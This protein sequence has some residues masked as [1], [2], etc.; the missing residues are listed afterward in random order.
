VDEPKE[1]REEFMARRRAKGD[2]DAVRTWIRNAQKRIMNA[3]NNIFDGSISESE[4][5][6]KAYQQAFRRWPPTGE[7]LSEEKEK[8]KEDVVHI[9][10]TTGSIDVAGDVAWAYNNLNNQ[11]VRAD[12]APSGGAWNM[13]IYG[14]ESRHKFLEMAARYDAQKKKEEEKKAESFEADAAGMVKALQK[15]RK[16][17][18]AVHYDAVLDAVRQAPDEVQ[19]ALREADWIVTRPVEKHGDTSVRSLREEA[20]FGPLPEKPAENTH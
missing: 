7:D 2:W 13:L 20:G 6:E 10:A 15:L 19:R 12:K 4:A 16:I 8:E 1:S 11:H 5:T 17:T 18:E 3:S 14:R 9:A